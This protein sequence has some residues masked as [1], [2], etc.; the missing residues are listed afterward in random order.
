[1]T[2]EVF[3]K[4]FDW[5]IQNFILEIQANNSRIKTYDL[6]ECKVKAFKSYNSLLH[7][8]K[9]QIFSKTDDCL[10]DRHRVASC[11]CGAFLKT[12]VFNKKDL[13]EQIRK[14]K[15]GVEAAFYYVNE[16][17]AFH[18]GCRYLSCFMANDHKNN[19]D[20]FIKI[21]NSFP[22][23]PQT[24]LVKK[25]FLNCI[26]FNLSQVK[27]ENQI[28]ITHYDMYAYAMLFFYLE[29]NFYRD[30]LP[31]SVNITSNI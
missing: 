15:T 26:L 12:P 8:Y 7:Q 23:L 21:M 20:V 29:Q 19:R 3:D 13:V 4:I 16:W 28:G 14:S 17:V 18:A 11:I 31:E 30:M 22:S 25:S 27:D 9:T 1:M 5:G 6:E 10:L 2:K 24:T